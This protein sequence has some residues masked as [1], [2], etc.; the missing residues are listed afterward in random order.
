MNNNQPE[1]AQAPEHEEIN[2]GVH[3]MDTQEGRKVRREKLAKRPLDEDKKDF[4]LDE[5]ETDFN[6]NDDTD[7]DIVSIVLARKSGYMADCPI[8]KG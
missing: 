5:F 1:Q 8:G 4:G 6:Q 3:A 7:L 2:T